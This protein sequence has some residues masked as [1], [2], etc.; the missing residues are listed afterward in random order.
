MA[1]LKLRI[2]EDGLRREVL[3]GGKLPNL[4]YEIQPRAGAH[5]PE[6]DG[7]DFALIAMLP[8][9]MSEMTDLKAEFEV[10]S[11]L[12]DGL[13]HYQEVWHSWRPDIFKKKIKI[14]TAGETFRSSPNRANRAVAAFSSG[15]DSTF[16]LSRHLN[17]DAGRA[18]RDIDTAVMV[19]GF[20]MP[21]EADGG[22]EVL[23]SNGLAICRD[24][25]VGLVTVK[26]NWR[27]IIPNW[28]MT[29]GAGL[30]SVLHQFSDAHDV[31]LIATEES[32]QNS[33]PVWGNSF[34]TDRFFSSSKLKIE[35]DGGV[36]DRI[37][38]ARYLGR[39]PQLVPHL[40]V[41][42]AGPRTGEN[43]GVCTKCVLTKLNFVAAGV[44][45]PWPFPQGLTADLINEMPLRTRWQRQFLEIILSK[46]EN[47]PSVDTAI[48]GAVRN[49][50]A[51]P[52]TLGKSWKSST[53]VLTSAIRSSVA[54]VRR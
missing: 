33:F 10:D 26:T 43:C 6:F 2:S 38:R 17:K 20:D 34:W 5:I 21:L 1:T 30:A 23:L 29:F 51:S 37:E 24:L 3:S 4:F 54:R 31:A 47:E 48:V 27:S 49:R 46:I 52:R 25:G 53:S 44:A 28:E 9:A 14:T 42:W 15:V 12:L 39:H 40:R 41:C 32:Y 50:L 16:T 35:S 18:V 8:I 11:T 36:Y 7:A 19:H 45:Q 13:D 22:F